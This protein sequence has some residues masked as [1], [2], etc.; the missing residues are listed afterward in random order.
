MLINHFVLQADGK[1]NFARHPNKS[2]KQ[3][4]PQGPPA[5]TD[6]LQKYATGHFIQLLS[7][8]MR[9]LDEKYRCRFLH[10]IS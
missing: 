2:M 5:D 3:T 4:A 8:A 10:L 1:V 9:K 7:F 6:F